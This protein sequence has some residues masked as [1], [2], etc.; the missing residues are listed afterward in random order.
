MSGTAPTLRW[1]ELI[2]E[3]KDELKNLMSTNNSLLKNQKFYEITKQYFNDV[4][5][6]PDLS[7]EINVFETY[8]LAFKF[9]FVPNFLSKISRIQKN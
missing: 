4:Q 9:M 8:K 6:E 2:V 3:Q 5:N 7:N 1:K